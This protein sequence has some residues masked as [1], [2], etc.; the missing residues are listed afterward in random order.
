M[1]ED[2][3]FVGPYLT[4]SIE[5]LHDT[6]LPGLTILQLDVEAAGN[7]AVKAGAK[8]GAEHA[9]ANHKFKNQSGKLESTIGW[10]ALVTTGANPMAEFFADAP[11][12][13]LV[14]DGSKPHPI[15]PRPGNRTGMLWWNDPK[16]DG[17]LVGRIHVDHPGFKGD[18]FMTQAKYAAEDET[19]RV[20]EE[21][22]DLACA[23]A[24]H[25]FGHDPG[26]AAGV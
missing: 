1:A 18:P 24:S 2:Y 26:S 23:K 25:F 12:A 11:Y 20:L 21:E 9:K 16:P 15:D 10:R 8:K 22:V 5:G 14:N 13:N 4:M 19:Q 17:P 3:K 6:V 7:K